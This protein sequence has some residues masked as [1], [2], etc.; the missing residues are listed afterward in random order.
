MFKV[1]VV[2]YQVINVTSSFLELMDQ[3]GRLR[4]DIWCP[5]GDL[6]KEIAECWESGEDIMVTVLQGMGESVAISVRSCLLMVV[7]HV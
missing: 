7:V 2:D 6:G 1:P 4:D 5:Q 3:A